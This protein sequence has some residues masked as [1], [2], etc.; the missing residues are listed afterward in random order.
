VSGSF[1]RLIFLLNVAFKRILFKA[2]PKF[3][4]NG[5]GFIGG[6]GIEYEDLIANFLQRKQAAPDVSGFVVSDNDA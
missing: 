3:L 2:H 6:K 4:A 1:E 5:L